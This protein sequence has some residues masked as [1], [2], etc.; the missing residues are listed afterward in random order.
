MYQVISALFRDEEDKLQ[1]SEIS[2]S[3]FTKS[4]GKYYRTPQKCREHWINHLDPGVNRNKWNVFED[5][6]LFKAIR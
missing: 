2:F 1:W 6:Q 4:E 3:M 5:L